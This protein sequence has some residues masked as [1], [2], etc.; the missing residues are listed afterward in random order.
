MK[1]FLLI[2]AC[3]LLTIVQASAQP[4]IGMS[5]GRQIE[6]D[7]ALVAEYSEFMVEKYKLNEEQAGKIRELNASYVGKISFPIARSLR[8]KVMKARGEG[9]LN[10]VERKQSDSLSRAMRDQFRRI[11]NQTDEQRQEMMAQMQKRMQELQ[12]A[13]EQQEAYEAEYEEALQGILDKSQLKAY[14]KEVSREEEREQRRRE[15]EMRRQFERGG[16]GPPGGFGG[17][18]GGGGFG[19]GFGGPGGGF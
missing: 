3:V 2:A 7:S 5:W 18:P 9:D 8:E 14:K 16:F 12:D 6:R 13:R 15:S 4:G 17:P 10:E 11:E 19:G 1:R